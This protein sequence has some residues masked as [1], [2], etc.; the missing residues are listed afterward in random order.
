MMCTVVPYVSSLIPMLGLVL[1]TSTVVLVLLRAGRN[2]L[3][4]LTGEIDVKL[5]SCSEFSTTD[6]NLSVKCQLTL[7]RFSRI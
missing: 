5:L 3:I 6:V 2:L 4:V 1:V 7:F